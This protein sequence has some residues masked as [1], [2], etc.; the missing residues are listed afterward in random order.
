MAEE[1]LSDDE[2]E[3]ALREWW[4]ENW[5]WILGGVVLGVA[6]LVGWRYWETHRLQ[7]AEGA[8]DLYRDIQ[9]ALNA[10]DVT[11]AEGLLNELVADS[12][13]GAYTQQARL[14][15]AKVQVE[16]GKFSDATPLL[17]AVVDESKDEELAKIAQL[18]LGQLLVQEGR[19]DEALQLLEPLTSG[20]FGAQARE[21]RGDAL[22][23]K[24]DAEGARAEYAAALTDA[25]APLD[26]QLV[27]LKLQDVGGVAASSEAPAPQIP[28]LEQP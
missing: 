5:S 15:L 1:Y 10:K 16:T 9:T 19:H 14:L 2:R 21:I 24:G 4:R 20:K 25:D 13:S 6:L 11:K 8:A 7:S 22:F 23:A 12:K 26:R 28:G 17:Q 3:E 27:E 18:R